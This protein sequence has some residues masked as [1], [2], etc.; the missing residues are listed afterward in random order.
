MNFKPITT[1]FSNEFSFFS[2]YIFIHVSI[3]DVFYFNAKMLSLANDS[4]EPSALLSDA[5]LTIATL[6]QRP[7]TIT[8]SNAFDEFAVLDRLID[9]SN[10]V[11][12]S[13]DGES[14]KFLNIAQ[15][16]SASTCIYSRRVDAL[17][18][19]INTFQSTSEHQRDE[20]I[21]NKNSQSESV[22]ISKQEEQQSKT[23][24]KKQRKQTHRSFICNDLTKINLTSSKQFFLDRTSLLDLKLFQKHVPI[25]NRSFWTNDT[26]PVIFDLLFNDQSIEIKQEYQQ[27]ES[28]QLI[29]TFDKLSPILHESTSNNNDILVSVPTYDDQDLSW[30][31]EKLY[32][33]KKANK[34]RRRKVK[35]G[36][37]LNIFRN[38][39]TDEQQEYFRLHK[40]KS[41]SNR[42]KTE[43]THFFIKKL[44]QLHFN[45]LIKGS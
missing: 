32:E 26:R 13:E 4:N 35:H 43:Q 6:I 15:L 21:S 5:R 37:G 22:L 30:N 24:I 25:G 17:Y 16:I 45:R 9:V 20:S 28:E 31:D 14:R 1:I 10:D 11:D 3:Y 34:N 39:P 27:Q 12:R 36:I 38:G 23:H 42:V 19:L 44:N 7:S 2:T 33:R 29:D 41:L 18:K 40:M 8:T